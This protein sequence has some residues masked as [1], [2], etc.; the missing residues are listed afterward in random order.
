MMK[1]LKILSAAMIVLVYCSSA[2]AQEQQQS[3]TMSKSL[4]LYV[5]PANEQ[6][7]EQQEMDEFQCYKWA[8]EQSGVDPMNPP[9]VTAEQVDTSPDGSAVGGAARG[10][11]AGA[12]IGAIAGDAGKGAAIGATAGAMRGRRSKV[13]SDAKQQEQATQQATATE[14]E[15]MNN[16]KRA[17]SVCLEGKD[18]TVK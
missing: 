5:F 4:N 14:A 18:Y 12:A 6:S 11:V 2:I 7:K 8:V 17:Y 13:A 3:F 15:L 16:F 1:K 9:E 10:A